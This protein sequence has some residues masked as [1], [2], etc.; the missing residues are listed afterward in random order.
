MKSKISILEEEKYTQVVLEIWEINLW[1][2]VWCKS[3]Y[4]KNDRIKIKKQEQN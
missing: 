2:E 4:F 1:L 3:G